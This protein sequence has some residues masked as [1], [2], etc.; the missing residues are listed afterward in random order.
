MTCKIRIL[1]NQFTPMKNTLLI[2]FLITAHEVFGQFGFEYKDSI[3]VK[4]GADTLKNAWAGG[5]SYAQFSDFDYDF[6]GDMDLFVF[7]RSSDNIRV[8]SQENNAGQKYYKLVP[9]AHLDFPAGITYR[10]TMVDYDM[11]GKKDLF[12]YGIGG[13][14]VYRNVGDAI[15][16]LQWS[17]SK[18]LLYSDNWGMNLN[19]YVSSADIPAIV[20]VDSD[21]DIDVLT[22]H[23]GGQHLQYHKNLSMEDFGVPDSL[24]FKLMN[25]CWGGFREDINTNSLFL[26]DN[27]PPC[28]EG[29][30]PNAES[31]VLDPDEQKSKP[32]EQMPKHSG[33]TVLALDYDG[34]GIMDL[35]L[36]DVAFDNLNLLINGGS[37]VNTNSDMIS[38]DPL[39]PSNSQPVDLEIF[40]AAF[41]VDVDFDGIKDLIVGTN[42]RNVAANEVSVLFYKNSGTNDQPTFIYQTDAFLQEQMIE[43]GTAT[44]PVL[45]D[46]DND[47]LEDLFV[48]NFFR[49]KPGLLKESSIAY[50]KNTGSATEPIFTFIDNDF[51]NL[52]SG[53]YG[54]RLFPTFGDITGD[55]LKDMIIGRE[56]GTLIYLKNNSTLP[57]ISFGTPITGLTDNQGAVITVDQYA[58]PQLFDL[59]KDGLLDLIIGKK[60]GELVYYQNIGTSAV[61]S[62]KLMNSLLG[63]IDIATDNPDGY[64]AP[65][66]F[67][68]DDTTYL[69]LGGVDGKLRF[70]ED[71]DEHIA[72]GQTFL[73]NSDNFLGINTGAY[74]SFFTA[75]IDNDGNVNLFAG[76]DLGGLYHYEVNPENTSSLNDKEVE[77]AVSVYP[78]PSKDLLTISSELS[79][80]LR[81]IVFDIMGNEMVGET[82]FYQLTSLDLSDQPNGIYIIQISN[83]QGNTVVKRIVK[84]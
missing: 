29:N 3:V 2:L 77:L 18:D 67:V 80:A 11:D 4:S 41:Y 66:F 82:E 15:N 8:F 23:I 52:A 44:I 19:L 79:G 53:S 69:F 57:S 26:N 72:T 7:D 28:A 16:G 46:I 83:E 30:L 75:D 36:G 38:V 64:P 5:L 59:N 25:E 78:N 58:A 13:I 71:F 9:D 45:A 32:T 49:H 33:S 50:Y 47:G 74:S 48:S 35:I 54:L 14:K 1:V 61:P 68:N 6:D 34:N 10:A 65:H 62:F 84:Q 12:C 43:H 39:F 81:F 40:P 73:L 20:D 63:G 51:L 76:Q 17:L 21:G 60:T 24:K 31:P 27:T 42:A 37:V 70:Y 55:G 22:F 56:N